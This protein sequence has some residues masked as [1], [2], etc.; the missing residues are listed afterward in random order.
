MNGCL[1]FWA[2]DARLPRHCSPSTQILIS[3]EDAR[4]IRE[5]GEYITALDLGRA[6]A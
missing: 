3:C 4:S 2:E 5:E 1:E 6:R